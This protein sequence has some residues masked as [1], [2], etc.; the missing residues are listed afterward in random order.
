[1]RPLFAAA[2]FDLDGTLID[3]ERLVIDAGERAL[4]DLGLTG[5]GAVLRQMVGTVGEDGATILRAAFGSGFDIDRFD[6]IWSGH[7][8]R[9]SAGPMPHRPG[10]ADL[11]DRLVALS[12]PRAVATNSRTD[13]A[14]RSLVSAGLRDRFGPGHVIGRDRV[15]APKPAP[16]VFVAAARA[17]GVAPAD[18]VAFEDSDT[19]VAA[20]LAAGMTVVQ[21]PDM[22]PAATQDAHLLAD[23]LLDGARRIGLIA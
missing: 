16:D 21:I 6:A 11:L 14:E 9:L 15:P 19:G 18:C 1:M 4:D 10:A 22:R 12:V 7:Y 13:G 23:S 8:R 17:L 3:S 2:I 20:A 5:G